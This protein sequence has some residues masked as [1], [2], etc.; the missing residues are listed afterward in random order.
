MSDHDRYY[1]RHERVGQQGSDDDNDSGIND[2][3]VAFSDSNLDEPYN[4]RRNDDGS[5]ADDEGHYNHFDD[6]DEFLLDFSDETSQH[7]SSSCSSSCSGATMGNNINN[8]QALLKK[9]PATGKRVRKGLSG[10]GGDVPQRKKQKPPSGQVVTNSGSGSRSSSSNIYNSNS[11]NNNNSSAKDGAPSWRDIAWHLR[12]FLL[13][14][15]GQ[16]HGHCNAPISCAIA[17]TGG[18]NSSPESASRS[19]SSSDSSGG[20][21]DPSDPNAMATAFYL[22]LQGDTNA[23]G[24]TGSQNLEGLEILSR[25]LATI[26]VVHLGTWLGTQRADY[27]NNTLRAD[28][29]EL[30]NRLVTEGLFKWQVKVVEPDAWDSMYDRLVQVCTKFGH[31]NIPFNF[32]YQDHVGA[33]ALHE[34]VGN[35][36]FQQKTAGTEGGEPTNTSPVTPVEKTAEAFAEVE[37]WGDSIQL[38]TVQ[39]IGEIIQEIPEVDATAT[40]AIEAAVTAPAAAPAGTI[41]ASVAL[42]VSAAVRGASPMA[43]PGVAPPVPLK[44]GQ[45]LA[46]QRQAYKKGEMIQYRRQKLQNLVD[47]GLL[48]WEVKKLSNDAMWE[49]NYQALLRYYAMNGHCNAPLWYVEVLDG[50]K[51]GLRVGKWLDRQRQCYKSNTLRVDRRASL[52][53]LCDQ[54]VLRWSKGEGASRDKDKAA[55]MTVAAAV[56]GYGYPVVGSEQQTTSVENMLRQAQAKRK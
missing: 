31:A 12:Y 6:D 39:V 43:P 4:D 34:T 22:H 32:I 29:K 21:A 2:Y 27:K 53:A 20:F 40:A 18:G 28:R 44:L 5:N 52:Q 54:S 13:L 45:W 55:S 14:R 9:M 51:T 16:A 37:A 50:G 42:A 48:E 41:A 56:T 19:S 24:I 49:Q 1:F 30:L 38:P 10:A 36:S 23:T 15:Y 11:S 35:E 33:V 46:T 25:W 8:R 47:A 26:E 7:D 3:G 17:L